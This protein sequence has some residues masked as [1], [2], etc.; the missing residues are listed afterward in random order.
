MYKPPDERKNPAPLLKH[1]DP[2]S[3]NVFRPKY[4]AYVQK[5]KS[6]QMSVPPIHRVLPKA[7]VVE[8][9]VPELLMQICR[10]ELHKKYRTK[11]PEEVSAMAV[12]H[13]RVM[14]KEKMPIELE[15]GEGITTLSQH[16]AAC[17]PS[18]QTTAHVPI[19]QTH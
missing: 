16:T 5:F 1:R 6:D 15:D 10:L 11:R 4:T 14:G 18:Q 9:I 17:A 2:E 8:C 12:Q 7:V 3:K 19:E 13:R